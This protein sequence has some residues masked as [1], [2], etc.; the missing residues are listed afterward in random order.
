MR[1]REGQLTTGMG[2]DIMANEKGVTRGEKEGK[3]VE[4]RMSEP[5]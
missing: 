3:R 2:V 1:E 5:I 4:G